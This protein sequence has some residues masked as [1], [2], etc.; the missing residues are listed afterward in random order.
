[1][2][3]AQLHIVDPQGHRIVLLDRPSMLI[4]RQAS[5]DVHFGS[6]DVSREH[7]EIVQQGTSFVLRDRGSRFGTF[8]NGVR[9]T[10]HPLR[11]GDRVRLGNTEAI[12]LIFSDE[13]SDTVGL[14]DSSTDVNGLRHMAA[15]LN[16]L[17]A[18]GS[19]R[20]LD[21][22]LA[23][24]LD[25]ALEV[26]KAER[27]FIMLA[28]VAGDLEFK[29]AR[30]RD[31]TPLPGTTFSTS[32]KIPKEVFST[33]RSKIVPDL[34]SLDGKHESTVNRG[35]RHVVC[36]PLRVVPMSNV[37]LPIGDE[38]VIGVLYMDGA[39][40][41]TTPSEARQASLEAFGT[42]A[43]LAIESA[44]LYADSA[45]KA[46]IER[47]LQFAADI[48]RAL[49]AEPSFANDTLDLAAQSIPCR[50]VGGDF[51]DYLDLGEGEFGVGLGDV[52][53]KG[54][55]AAL[56]AAA[57]QANFAAQATVSS[58]P[59]Q[60]L[61]RINSALLRRAIDARFATMFYGVLRADGLLRYCNAGHEPPLV[62]RHG[63]LELLE[64]G[65]PVL[66]LLPNATYDIGCVELE[67]GDLIVVCSDGL[68]EMRNRSGDEFGRERLM[69]AA[70]PLHGGRPESVLEHLL[71][72]LRT[73][74][75]GEAP[76]DDITILVLRY[77]G[78]VW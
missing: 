48:Q 58:D 77:R 60:T 67:P 8:V 51:Y 75:D 78:Q 36:V 12:E 2:K 57:V 53:G 17:R 40:P 27:G 62:V 34:R 52:A 30:A 63:G 66:G 69:A 38:R 5:A 26:S 24:V 29:T 33:G 31:R 14:L 21:E 71:V 72:T 20:V 32:E 18:L 43:A 39:A 7:A 54:P 46:R 50:T 42:Q 1:M 3:I 73:F 22:V 68:T 35:I 19:G 25:C 61:E 23:L 16:G 44:R 65:G 37:Q 9:V 28:N 10:E 47:D 59:A 49:L 13:G 6:S 74:A 15:V 55:A 11:H 70:R 45:E 4:G 64:T 41:M 76:F 56:L